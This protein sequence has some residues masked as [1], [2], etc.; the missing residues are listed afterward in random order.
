MYFLIY[1]SGFLAVWLVDKIFSKDHTWA[2][3]ISRF[4]LAS[5]SWASLVIY[6]LIELTSWIGGK[7]SEKTKKSP[8]SWL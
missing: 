2:V 6:F 4:T 8:P 1:I 3:V 5:L 7:I